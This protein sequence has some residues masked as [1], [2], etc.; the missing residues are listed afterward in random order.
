MTLTTAV[1]NDGLAISWE[2]NTDLFDD[3]TIA[4]LGGHFQTLITE[5]IANPKQRLTSL[6]LL[7][8]MEQQQLLWE[9]N[10]TSKD[11]PDLYIHQLFDRQVA[12]T[13]DS[14]ALVFQDQQ[15]TYQQLS[16]YA[17]QLANYLNRLG[18]GAETSVGIC[19]E[20]GLEMV[21]AVLAILKAGG[22]YVP[23]DPMLPAERINFV[24]ADAQVA[25]LLTQQSLIE[26]IDLCTTKAIC[27]DTNLTEF[28]NESIEAP[29]N[30]VS[31]DNLAYIIYTSGST[32]KPKGVSITQRNYTSSYLAW[33]QA[34]QLRS[35][36]SHL[37][38]ANISFDVFAGDLARALC[39]GGKLVLCP[40]ELL[41]SPEQLYQL[42]CQQGVDCAEFIPAVLRNLVQYL[43]EIGARLDFMRLLIAGSES[44]Y[45]NEYEQ[46]R[47]LCGSDTRLI[48]SYGVT[49]A[50]IDSSYFEHTEIVLSPDRAVPIGHP[51]IN[52]QLYVLDT[53]MQ[54]MPIGVPGELH[55]GG[56]G[57]ARGYF[58]DP[59][60]TAARF[61]PNPFTLELGTR[62]YKTGDRA[63]YLSDG[64]IE[65]LGRLDHQVKIRGF[66]I[67]LAEI[68]AVLAQHPA[69]QEVAVVVQSESNGIRRLIAYLV[70]DTET[71]SIG[72]LRAFA[73]QRLP[74]YMLPAIFI[75]LPALPR[76]PNG[77]V[78]RRA[79][80]LPQQDR[81]NLEK[82]FIAP[83]TPVQQQLA[84][85]WMELL[86]LEVVGIYDNFFALGG[87][88]I[89]SIQVV[90]RA[91]Q[92][93]LALTPNQIFEYQTIAELAAITGHIQTVEAEQGLVTG[94][95]V[96]TPIQRWFWEQEFAEPHHWN[97]SMLVEVAREL[98]PIL[99]QQAMAKLLIHHD[100]LRLR[101]LRQNHY[102][103]QFIVGV[104]NP[105][106]FLIDLS[107][108]TQIDQ[109]IALNRA[110]AELQ[111]KLNLSQGPLMQVTLFNLG[112]V[113]LPRLSIIIHHLAVD[114]ISWR[115][116]LEDLA[117]ACQQLQRSEVIKLPAKTTSFKR[118]SELL[119]EYAQSYTVQAELDYWLADCWHEVDAI[120]VDYCNAINLQAAA[121]NVS[122]AL[123]KEET[124]ALLQNVPAV[125][126]TQINDLLLTALTKAFSHCMDVRALLIELEGH[127]R[128]EIMEGVDLSRTIGWFTTAF[129]VRLVLKED[130]TPAQAIKSIK[131][132]LRRIPNRGLGYGLLRY[133]SEQT[134]IGKKLQA[135][136]Q[137]QV[138]FNYLGQFDQTFAD[139][140]LFRPLPEWL[141]SSRSSSGK[142]SHLL[143]I[144]SSI[145]SEQLHID[146]CYSEEFYR[147]ESI[148][149][150][151][152]RFLFELR[153]L[154]A[155]CQT[156]E[157]GGYT[158]SDFPLARLDQE[159]V[160][161]LVAMDRRIEDIYPLS[162]TQQ[163]ILFHSLHTP[164]SGVYI[165][166]L[167]FILHGNLNISAFKQ[168]W[169]QVL[170]RHSILR[171]A[172]VW[173]NLLTPL[174]LVYREV[175]LPLEELDWHKLSVVEQA[176][177]W[178]ALL[179]TDQQR[180]FVLS[181][182]PLIRLV[183]IR[184]TSDSYQF[185]CS[186]HHLLLDGWSTPLLLKEVFAYYEAFCLDQPLLLEHVRP[187]RDYICWVE[188][189]DIT[190]AEGYWKKKLRGFTTPTQIAISSVNRD[191]SGEERINIWRVELS[192]TTTEALQSFARHHHLTLSVLIQSAWALLLSCYSG[193]RD[194][195]FGS[196]VSG[197]TAALAG[198]ESMIGLFINTLPMRV[199][200]IPDKTLLGLLNGIQTEQVEMRQYEY[201]PLVEIQGW[202]EV[203]RG[204]A[205]FDSILVFENYPLNPSELRFEQNIAITDIRSFDKTNYP[206]T[207]VV[208]PGTKLLVEILYA[209]HLFDR[210]V[211]ERM[212][213]HLQVLLESIITQPEQRLSAISILTEVERQQLLI[214]WNQTETVYPQD[215]CVHQ[216]FEQQVI[217]TPDAIAVVFKDQQLNYQEL[218]QRSN[219]LAHYLSSLG[220]GPETPV[221]ICLERSVEMVIGILGIM[222]VGG[223]YVPLDA[224]YPSERLA[225]MI[226]DA[227]ISFLLTQH[228]LLEKLPENNAHIVCL[229]ADWEVI[230]RESSENFFCRVTAENLAY[231]T[232]TSG[233]TGQPKG[234]EV[235][236]RGILRL[237]FGVDYV[238]LGRD[239]VFLQMARLAF[240][241]S[242]FEIW[243]ALLHGGE[244]V[245]LAD[246][247]P[248]AKSLGQAINKYGVTTLWLTASLFNSVIDE[249]AVQLNGV[250]QLLIGG[251]A[252][253]VAHVRKGLEL[254][255]ST[256]IIN[257]YGPTE[258][259]TFTCCYHINGLV[260]DHIRSIP[261]GRPIG[262]TQVYILDKRLL[263]VPVGIVGE[264]YIG[265]DG[266]ARG[267]L[268]SPELTAE[269]FIPNPF[270]NHPGARLY[271]TGDLAIYLPDTNIEFVGRSDQQVKVRGFRI[272]LGEIE[273]VIAQHP[274][275][276][277]SI[278][279]MREDQPGNKRLIAYL[280]LKAETLITS[281]QLREYL[282]QR[283]PDY[284]LPSGYVVLE[285]LP[286]TANGKIDR[287]ALPAPESAEPALLEQIP[288]S[289]IAEI[290]AAV[291][292][293][294]LA[295][296]QVGAEDN[297]FEL[298]G[299]SLLATQVTSRLS[300][301]F[302]V[303]ISVRRLFEYSTV[304][305]LA[306]LIE[307][308]I[309]ME[310]RLAAPAIVRVSREQI[311]PLSYAQ[312]RLWFL[313]QLGNQGS[314]YNMAAA[315][316]MSGELSIEA[317]VEAFS[318]I[319][320]RHETLRTTFET[321]AG[322]PVQ[323]INA[324]QPV[325]IPIVDVSK[326][327]IEQREAVAAEL[328]NAEGRTVF[329][330]SEGPLLRVCLVRMQEC[331]HILIVTMHHIVTDGWSVG[332][333]IRELGVLYDA[334]VAGRASP[335]AELPIQYAD[336]A[337]WQREWLQAEVLSTQLEYWRSQ[338]S[339][340]ATR[341]ALPS[342]R[343]RPAQQ[344]FCGST[345][346]FSISASL[347]TQL[348]Q[349][350]RREGATLF[351]VMLAG[352]QTLLYRYSNESEISI[353]T[354]IANRN[355]AEI[356]GLIGF[357]VNTLVM[358]SRVAGGGSFRELLR[359][360]REVALGAYAHQD[361]PFEKLVE[362]LQPS[363]DL[364]HSPFF[365][366]MLVLQNAPVSVLKLSDLTLSLLP[367][368][369]DIAKF[370]LTLFIE[371]SRENLSGIL[372]YN[373]DL[374]DNVT[375]ERMAT[376]LQ[377]LLN[378]I[379]NDPTQRIY[380]LHLLTSA[381]QDQLLIEWNQTEA[382]YPQGKCI[383]Q[384]FEE[385]VIY[386]PDA[387][388]VV[389]KQ[390][391][392]S[393]QELNQRANQLAYYLKSLGVGPE[394]LVG[395]CV[396]RSLEMV[397]GILGIMKAGGAYLP[398][399]PAYPKERLAFML[400]DA[401]VFI[402]LTQSS[403]IKSLPEN[404][405][406]IVCLDRDLYDITLESTEN[407]DSRVE[408]QGLSYVIY[409]SGSTG[410]PKGV[411]IAH[412][413]VVNY[414]NWCCQVYQAQQGQGIPLHSSLSFDLTVTSLLLPLVV[415]QRIVI[416]AEEEGLEGLKEALSKHS[417]F[418]LVK[419]TPA[420]LEILNQQLLDTEAIDSTRAL[421][422]GGEAL[423]AESLTY[424]HKHS[425]QTRIFNE[426][427]PTEAT[428][429]CSVYQ[430][431]SEGNNSGA[432]SIGQPIA[433]TQLYILDQYH[434]A[435][436]VGVIG[437]LYIGGVGLARGYL[438]RP[439]LTA[440]KF[441][442]NPFSVQSGAKLYR[443]G[444]L[445]RFLADG[446]IEFLGRLDQQ[447][448]I[449]GFRIELGEIESILVQHTVV[450]EAVVIVR[451][452]I[453]A[454][455]QLVAYVVIDPQSTV[456]VSELHSFL[457]ERLAYHMVP[458]AFV[459]LDKL[460]LTLNGKI[461]RNK[462][463][464]PDL[465]RSELANEY[466]APR[467][468][469]EEVITAIWTEMLRIERIGIHD[470][471]F[472][473]GGHSLLAIKTI[474]NINYIF[475]IALPVNL[476]FQSPTV[477][478]LSNVM[479]AYEK[480]SGQIE[481]IAE[482]LKEM[483]SMSVEDTTEPLPQKSDGKK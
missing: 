191:L 55:I 222:K 185:L 244:C 119:R 429:G 160:D 323:I 247:I 224:S 376:H 353:G 391:E 443:T 263:P 466:T 346:E 208:L 382:V 357:F 232:Y 147:C 35:L 207:V 288:D 460:P 194:V 377:V 259:T 325:T 354:P 432:V 31:P 24:L 75:F 374:F 72:E 88:S 347:S 143:E 121:R 111:T 482:I 326:L 388:A 446:N 36:T 335:L 281:A 156:E 62:L 243:G 131:E 452:D 1:V 435:V 416:I 206:L 269:K 368:N 363:R 120:P 306:K 471:F 50:A 135:L 305:Q 418:S 262:N 40:R 103:Q 109:E 399:D 317:L 403:L 90:A 405:G 183:L 132:Q 227:Q 233:T 123:T 23:I 274:A 199:L 98:T 91:R 339:V 427:G 127:G 161:R 223:A 289:P 387:I 415:G 202:S 372:E 197:R 80:P 439:D 358:R 348:R 246:Q 228:H 174:Q 114:G 451:E 118:W 209:D 43:S 177:Q 200:V 10:N 74:E 344:S 329:D 474:A 226:E 251:E 402:L 311:L 340:E 45:M 53:N 465:I 7:T 396:E 297:F 398:L 312:R 220:V 214:E 129:P 164:E 298:G 29:I 478:E 421:V 27:L 367:I 469:I 162:H 150:L 79:L 201:S 337:V 169:Q 168:A 149:R 351:M 146:W 46:I 58:N 479:I 173:Q 266:L 331:E 438:N 212:Q 321:V 87:D 112:T 400:T 2:Y 14:I 187:Y 292:A 370:D 309:G 293:E 378:A 205:L 171:T 392:L 37:Q 104:E 286:L 236:H 470:N 475:K 221:G 277:E 295:V 472:D 176:Q 235:R 417:D 93:G 279:L 21:G 409:T 473:L 81:F 248:T 203:P 308:E 395:I 196:T 393:Y 39:S 338:L 464:M 459:L 463:P 125:Y 8:A 95:V 364:S 126:H 327:A 167:S 360:V 57:L 404:I 225:F 477:A 284:M 361:L 82:D 211:V 18:V 69:I 15:W 190:K 343:P 165:G 410:K 318:E 256:E 5:I 453:L 234:V 13:P 250:K 408:A 63:R 454:G 61:I 241:A 213:G 159:T 324:A 401:K 303:E 276:R 32:G 166:Q 133:L 294:V 59:R 341:L 419:L 54:A 411:M 25:L 290:V 97:L 436:P 481:R 189:Q 38:M 314:V 267:Y 216:L 320:R 106:L 181:E 332:I 252:L 78:D 102:W 328:A 141:E 271:G 51:L 122:V 182:S 365:Q 139:L 198:I 30:R 385:Q 330:L 20:R 428:V 115:I 352:L 342:D 356:E 359:R 319:V 430:V 422:I 407:P 362:E 349:V 313:Q 296:E 92:A 94:E 333:L 65:F 468:A 476:L 260:T 437:E 116:L 316:R 445:A 163:G 229:D 369:N 307:Q 218:N 455:K 458:A 394:V 239:K 278:V 26:R 64:N 11:F 381:E 96:L 345:Y 4:R 261:I 86:R 467:N 245:L 413:S 137:P 373:T 480:R 155:H 389:Y 299:H 268:N 101:F 483:E 219:Q 17:N 60:L 105:Q 300:R 52:T 383:H 134:D 100:G 310:K 9:W 3:T 431:M 85:I 255:P 170:E 420:H 425:P 315:E 380:S 412:Q 138:S 56:N 322:E 265:G 461:D 193:E 444:D 301:I 172:F 83:Q 302:Q 390:I 440:E 275:V 33:E 188:Q 217:R 157:A 423:L 195:M 142:R 184:L 22:T 210:T 89:L 273:S 152:E 128:E 76:T 47:Q 355:R 42:I 34:Y 238:A 41:L 442:P 242:T 272:E 66:R 48:N 350:A 414:L 180:G 148:E 240:D 154:I 28:V 371:E 124:R 456:S 379:V 151:A 334:Y 110:V 6:A 67:E 16:H 462:L 258:S 231:I 424:W 179:V 71:P 434:Q 441:I 215:K 433:N 397:I 77:K 291:W 44:W 145:I 426:Y 406:Q 285:Q 113:N 70:T 12:H 449:R 158:P 336:Y 450:H 253:S 287:R 153:L 117:L 84:R 107:Q 280:V 254:L 49:E 384:L 283:M 140:S 204:T 304:N 73:K 366:V 230:T 237:L 386:T 19:I 136:P 375:I 447:V 249:D 270:T 282:K 186:H 68:E 264:L 178:E 108:L 175:L 448:K 144:N 130:A 257:G 457:K 99:L 192:E